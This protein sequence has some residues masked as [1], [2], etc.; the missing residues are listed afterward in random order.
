MCLLCGEVSAGQHGVAVTERPAH[1]L[2]GLF[3]E[4]SHRQAAD[5]AIHGVINRVKAFSDRRNSL[6]KSPIVGLSWND[7]P[8][9]FRYFVGIATDAGEDAP[10]EFVQLELPEMH[11]ASSWH[12]PEDGEVVAHYGRMIQWVRDEGLAWDV[13]RFHHREEYP[14]DVDLS[15]PPAL[16]LLIPISPER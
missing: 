12:G 11:L 15:R 8:D 1:S 5:G 3:W 13:S 9:G 6:W 10:A 14:A 4:G 2:A 7:R 16:R